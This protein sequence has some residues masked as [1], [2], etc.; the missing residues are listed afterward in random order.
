M[1]QMHWQEPGG[2]EEEEE[3]EEEEGGVEGGEKRGRGR[4]SERRTHAAQGEVAASAQD[5][6]K[7]GAKGGVRVAKG[8]VCVA[9][10]WEAASPPPSHA[11]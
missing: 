10:K 9:G 5:L 11:M 1:R 6:Q 2:E 8:G 7:M 4:G 3:E